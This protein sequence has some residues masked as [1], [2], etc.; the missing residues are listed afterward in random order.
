MVVGDGVNDAIAMKASSVGVAVRGSVEGSL[1]AA[2]VY[3]TK[4]G[5]ESIY[6]LICASK[7]LIKVIYRNIYFSLVYN[8]IGVYLAFTGEVTPL[9]AAILMPLS[10]LTVLGSTLYSNL[11]LK[12][13]LKNS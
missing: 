4:S 6:S 12:R 11:K 5:V 1:R 3:L 13:L 7:H 9:V 10:S 8:L 2:D